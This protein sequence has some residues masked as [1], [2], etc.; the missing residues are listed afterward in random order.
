MNDEDRY[1]ELVLKEADQ[2]LSPVEQQ[3][4]DQWL[5]QSAVNQEKAA[6]AREAWRT[7][8][9]PDSV[10]HLDLEQEY[11]AV[12]KKISSHNRRITLRNWSVA[13]AIF[14]LIASGIIGVLLT[15][16]VQGKTLVIEGP[17]EQYH[18]EDGS[19]V[20]LKQDSK[21]EVHFTEDVRRTTF[22]GRGFFEVAPNTSRP[23]EIITDQGN[24]T[25]VGTS[26]E[27]R[28]DLS[29]LKVIVSTGRVKLTNNQQD[30]IELAAGESG[31]ASPSNLEKIPLDQ[32]AGAW[33]LPPV[34]YQQTELGVIIKEIESKYHVRFTTDNTVVFQCKVTFTLDY[35]D[36]TVLFRIL[37]TLLDIQIEKLSETE[38][39]ITGQGC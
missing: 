39:Q 7:S 35:P 8:G 20:W 24:V 9:N 13:A 38:Y 1:I 17:V 6:K 26:F 29:K 10:P 27:V 5:L 32:P 15:R 3:E 36:K 21:L 11:A 19:T 33:M 30:Q 25:V 22:S 37:E 4:L 34:N 28:A 12:Q 16:S 2:G 18:L 14:L 23:F 31:Q